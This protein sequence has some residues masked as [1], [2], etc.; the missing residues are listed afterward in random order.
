[1]ALKLLTAIPDSFANDPVRPSMKTILALFFY[2][3]LL[4]PL[5]L[6]AQDIDAKALYD[7]Y[8]RELER[9]GVY[10]RARVLEEA[11]WLTERHGDSLALVPASGG[12]SATSKLVVRL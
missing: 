8:C 12:R 9:Q 7:A 2:L 11:A 3:S 10:D 4:A 1:M 6:L 5:P